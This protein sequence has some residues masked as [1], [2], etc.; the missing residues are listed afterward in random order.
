MSGSSLEI[1]DPFDHLTISEDE[2]NEVFLNAFE[3]ASCESF[4]ERGNPTDGCGVYGLFYFGD[5]DRYERVS[6]DR[7]ECEMPIYIGKAVPE[8]SRKGGAF[9]KTDHGPRLHRRLLDHRGSIEQAENLSVSDFRI[10]R[11]VINPVWSRYVEQLFISYFKPWWNLCIDGFG[12]HDVGSGRGDSEVPIWDSIH[13]GRDWLDRHD[14]EPRGSADEVWE[15]EVEPEIEEKWDEDS[16]RTLEPVE[17]S[18]VDTDI[19]DFL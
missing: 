4:P 6:N 19:S 7:W 15:E 18:A 12:N 16:V 1:L 8:G 3:S 2:L 11:I 13:P 17:D 10:K 14:L 9:L 5:I